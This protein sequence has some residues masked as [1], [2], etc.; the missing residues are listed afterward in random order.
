MGDVGRDR[1][2]DKM[3]VALLVYGVGQYQS[4]RYFLIAAGARFLH[5]RQTRPHNHKRHSHHF[6]IHYLRCGRHLQRDECC[7]NCVPVR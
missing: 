5:H 4:L 1:E 3:L 7:R 2:T 6:H